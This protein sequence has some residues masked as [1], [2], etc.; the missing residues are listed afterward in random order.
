[1]KITEIQ[2]NRERIK[3]N[4]PDEVEAAFTLIPNGMEGKVTVITN[5]DEY[6]DRH[7]QLK[8]LEVE[9]QELNRLDIFLHNAIDEI[10]QTKLAEEIRLNEDINGELKEELIEDGI[11][12]AILKFDGKLIEAG[13][14]MEFEYSE[15]QSESDT[16]FIEIESKT[17]DHFI[18][19]IDEVS[20][21][22]WIFDLNMNEK[23][24][25]I[26]ESL[27]KG[28]Q[29]FSFPAIENPN[30]INLLKG[31]KI[32]LKMISLPKNFLIKNSVKG[33]IQAIEWGIH[34]KNLGFSEMLSPKEVQQVIQNILNGTNK[35]PLFFKRGFDR[36]NDVNWTA[37]KKKTLL[38]IP[39]TFGNDRIAFN[40][41]AKDTEGYTKLY[42]NYEKLICF[43]HLTVG[44]SC[45]RNVKSFIKK[46]KKTSFSPQNTLT[47]NVDV[48]TRS[49]GGLVIRH[50]LMN[51]EELA[52]EGIIINVNKVFCI[53]SPH[54]G[55]PT[56]ETENFGEFLDLMSKMLLSF[57]EPAVTKVIAGIL[58]VISGVAK[59]FGSLKGIKSQRVRSKNKEL[60]EV[61]KF[62]DKKLDWFQ[63]IQWASFASNFEPKKFNLLDGIADSIFGVAENDLINP[64]LGAE[65][66][67]DSQTYKGSNETSHLE[68]CNA[69]KDLNN[70]GDPNLL[71]SILDWFLNPS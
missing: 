43:N 2:P 3:I 52:K 5:M 7:S 22:H 23:E 9:G 24:L 17:R 19:A 45:T 30:K 12:E 15:S 66:M 28:P 18:F 63:N 47:L 42:E 58:T 11:N 39:G 25:E 36:W 6:I 31:P 41:L 27:E 35:K 68:Y 38:L 26:N 67:K 13:P 40:G 59:G 44:H 51:R 69:G 33:L 64:V 20:N 65:S 50:L 21:P 1:M 61:F 53:S 71:P 14:W 10:N 49:R 16:P 37:G 34:V 57:P 55:T 32:I 60:E 70:V 56:A 62:E 8:Y 54:Q 29:V 48:L 4:V 46:F